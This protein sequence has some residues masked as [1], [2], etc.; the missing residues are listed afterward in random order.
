MHVLITPYLALILC[1]RHHPPRAR[2]EQRVKVV[3]FGGVSYP[4]PL[5]CL[6]TYAVLLMVHAQQALYQ[7]C[8]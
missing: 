5:L 6:S 3:F 2:M 8:D 7:L 1:R 4:N